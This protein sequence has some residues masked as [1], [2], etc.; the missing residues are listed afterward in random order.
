MSD[1][2]AFYC[3]IRSELPN[4]GNNMGNVEFASGRRLGWHCLLEGQLCMSVLPGTVPGVSQGPWP[5]KDIL[6]GDS[7]SLSLYGH[8]LAL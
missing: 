2:T 3:K 8:D 7:S 1:N 6:E 4:L 5:V